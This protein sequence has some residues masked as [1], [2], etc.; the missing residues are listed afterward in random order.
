MQQSLSKNQRELIFPSTTRANEVSK[1]FS[2]WQSR[3]ELVYS[4]EF[5]D[6]REQ[7]Y[8]AYDSHCRNR[9]FS[10]FWPSNLPQEYPAV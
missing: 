1:W 2:I 8:T 9:P 10:K 6:F 3:T 4:V 7:K 5:A